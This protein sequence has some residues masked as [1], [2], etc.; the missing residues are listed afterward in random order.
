MKLHIY[1]LIGCPYSIKSESMLEPYEPQIIKVEQNEKNKYKKM[2]N[3]DTFPQIFLVNEESGV[4]IK[5]GGLDST[6]KL[7]DSIFNKKSI[8]YSTEDAKQLK[9]FFLNK[10]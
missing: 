6:V 10:K 9:K 1:S 8:D 4:R 7:L 2:N 3:M 5:I